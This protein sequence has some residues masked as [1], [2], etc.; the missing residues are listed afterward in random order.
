MKDGLEK[1]KTTNRRTNS[2]NIKTSIYDTDPISSY[3]SWLSSTFPP[4][5]LKMPVPSL[6]QKTERE[7][8]QERERGQN[9]KGPGHQLNA[10]LA[11]LSVGSPSNKHLPQTVLSQPVEKMFLPRSPAIHPSPVSCQLSVEWASHRTARVQPALWGHSSASA[12][13]PSQPPWDSLPVY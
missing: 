9:Q 2:P 11:Q 6:I 1:N 12:S 8:W 5:H 3:L 10:L 7:R 4:H 13:T